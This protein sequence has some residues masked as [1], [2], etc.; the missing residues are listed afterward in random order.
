MTPIDTTTTVGELVREKPARSRV[1]E[2]FK[3]DYCCG[4]KIPLAEACEKR[5][6]DADDVLR[7]LA[8][9]EPPENGT[10]VDADA[11]SLTDLADHI[12]ST[13]HDYLREELPR[14]DFMTRK[15]AS[16]HGE[17]GEHGE[18]E[19]RLP[20]LREVYVA[21]MEEIVQHMMKEEQI[22][23]PMV[24]TI[25]TAEATP[26]FHCGSLANPIQVMESEHDSAG[27][28]LGRFR[29]LTDDFTPPDWACNTFRALYDAL[30]KLEEDMHQHI[31]KEN[32][33]LFPKA[34]RRE[35]ELAAN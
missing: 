11:M 26:E 24:R 35:A 22:L 13:H 6:I 19:T 20:E 12:V 33:V 29:T 8:D 7:A 32:N 18:H 4:G 34:L 9:A 28:A 1:F 15:V 30:A 16:V 23:F 25:D 21:F 10:I 17:H 27:D 31:H 3:I 14:L 5:D 2:Q